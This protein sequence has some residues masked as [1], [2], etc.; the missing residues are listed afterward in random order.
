MRVTLQS[1]SSTIQS[2]LSELTARQ[3]AQQT[4]IATGQ[5]LLQLSDAPTDIADI[6]SYRSMITRMQRY[7]STLDQALAEQ[8]TAEGALE[9]ISSTLSGIQ[10]LGVDALQIANHDKWRTLAVQVRSYIETIIE[11]ANATHGDI[12]VFA[13]TKN[14]ASVLVPTPPET[15]QRPFELV[16]TTPTASN[17]SGLEV[18]FKGN[19]EARTVQT[20]DASAEQVS[21]TADKIFGAGGTAL[22]DTLIALYNALAY[23]PDGS[24]RADGQIPSADQ[25]EKVSSLVTQIADASTTVNATT[26]QLGIRTNRMASLQSQLQEDITRHR[27]FLS[28]LTDTDVAQATMQLQRDQIAYE[29][30]LKVASRLLNLSLFDFLR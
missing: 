27:E 12:Y 14:T 16:T 15:T 7:S 17:P 23:N 19:T 3:V 2:Q 4:R 30:S 5:R 28:R 20:G 13:G 21:T 6:A 18:R 1:L 11:A 29:Y 10:T 9:S 8:N 22:F 25:L 24:P 26:A